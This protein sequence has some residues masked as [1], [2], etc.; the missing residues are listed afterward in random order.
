MSALGFCRECGNMIQKHY[1]YCPFCG[2]RQG[3]EPVAVG[4]ARPRKAGYATR[5]RGYLD[6]LQHL[7]ERLS[8]IDRELNEFI[9]RP[10]TPDGGQRPSATAVSREIAP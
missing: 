8:L 6:R 9:A 10:R 2:D 7:D 4:A 1:H 5:T 3:R